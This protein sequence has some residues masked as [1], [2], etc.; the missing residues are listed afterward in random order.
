MP[1][2]L[3]DNAAMRQRPA[4]PPRKRKTAPLPADDSGKARLYIGEWIAFMGKTQAEVS[5]DSDVNEGYLSQLISGKYDKDP[6][7]SMLE[8]IS[9]A[10]GV[11]VQA[12]FSPPPP[13]EH[14]EAFQ[15]IRQPPK[16][17]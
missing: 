2:R 15:A 13:R 7:L 10:I 9:D 8:A 5:R 16:G 11:R 3:A 12:L 6:R 4:P 1:E 14:Y 17:S